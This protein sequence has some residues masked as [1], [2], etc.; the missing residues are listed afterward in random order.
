MP[1]VH[2]P[3]KCRHDT[4]KTDCGVALYP[5]LNQREK[6]LNIV[7]RAEISVFYEIENLP[8]LRPHEVDS[9]FCLKMNFIRWKIRLKQPYVAKPVLLPE[10][11]N[12][13]PNGFCVI[14]TGFLKGLPQRGG[15]A[16]LADK[17]RTAGAFP[18]SGKQVFPRRTAGN[19]KIPVAV[20]HPDMDN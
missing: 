4:G 14:D 2:K 15:F 3:C 5:F 11:Q 1:A 20:S 13:P 8:L 16:V 17:R 19:K 10:G 9:L 7:V 6:V 18:F 12:A